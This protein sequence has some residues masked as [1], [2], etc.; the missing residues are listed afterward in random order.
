MVFEQRIVLLLMRPSFAT[1]SAYIA[2]SLSVFILPVFIFS[3]FTPDEVAVWFVF[4]TLQGMQLLIAASTDQPIIRGLAFALGGATQV[5]DM[6]EIEAYVKRGKNMKLFSRVCAVSSLAHMVIGAATLTLLAVMGIWSAAPLI[7]RT[8]IEELWLGLGVF[9]LGGA[10]RA[11]GGQHVSYL[12]AV[13]RI[14][15]L[16]W[17]ETCFW[18]VAFLTALL[19][20][21]FWGSLLSIAI[22]YQFP[23]ILNTVWNAWLCRWDQRA[24]DGFV[25]CIQTD[26]EI[27]AQLWPSIWRTG[28]G[29]TLFLGATQG[30]C[31]Y[32]AT[33]GAADDVAAFLFTMSLIRPLG[34]FAQV[35]FMTKLPRLAR[36]QAEGK[37]DAQ[38]Q[39]ALQSMSMSYA[40]HAAM[41]IIVSLALPLVVGA[42]GSEVEV[43][44]LLWLLIGVAGYLE[45][46]GS[47]HLQLYATTNHIL[48]HWANGMTALFYIGLAIFFAQTLEVYAFPTSQILSLIFCYVPLGMWNSYKYFKFKMP[49]FEV[50][51][52]IA[53][54]SCL[55][56]A[57]LLLT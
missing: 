50:K 24:R 21:L 28:V 32:Y 14:A 33:V 3:N 20:V 36:L 1:W 38:R 52:S 13:E 2:K 11:Y 10:I 47:M 55:L 7:A 41:V 40:L 48:V 42:R 23:L 22:A 54:L 49:E 27:I 46:M 56:L 12:M 16:R 57:I 8:Q 17:S 53:P 37:R 6:R 51:T 44:V 25:T 45:R 9:V 5:H 19:A 29:S 18:L 43:P 34:Q 15:L 4:I 39:I 30:S 31:L 26:R 35:P